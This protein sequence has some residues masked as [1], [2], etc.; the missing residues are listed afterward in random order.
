MSTPLSSFELWSKTLGPRGDA[1]EHARE[2]LR[3]SFL[4]F[5]ERV[6]QLVS[7]LGA[8][9]PGL[10]VHDITHIDALWRVANQI[11]GPDYPLNPAEAYVLGGAFLLHDSAHVLAAYPRG[12]DQ[13]KETLHWQDLIAQRYAGIQPPRHSAEEKSAL[14]QVLR[15]VHAEQAHVLAK[16][17][18]SSPGSSDP[19]YLIENNELRSYYADLIGE[20]AASH[21]WSPD[22]TASRFR[23]RQV[24]CPAFL[25]VDA[26]EVDALKI[27]FLLRTADAA[28]LDDLR[29]PWFLFALRQ[30]QGVSATHW[31][32]QA[33]LGQPKR[34]D[35]GEL[36]LGSGSPFT[37]T[38]RD[39]WWMAYDVAQMVDRELRAAHDI[40]KEEGRPEFAA[41]AVLGVE[42]PRAF[43]R[44]V[45]AR[46]WEPID[47]SP[48]VGNLPHLIS[49]LGG[50][51]LY[52]DNKTAPLRELLQ[53]ALDAVRALRGLGG[54]GASEGEVRVSIERAGNHEWIL[55]V[56]DDGIGMSRHVLTDVLMDFGT[57]LWASDALREELP[58]LAKSGFESVG[59]FGIGF[60]S[61]FMLGSEVKVTTRRYLPGPK[62][63]SVHWQLNFDSGLSTRPALMKPAAS[64]QLPK[65]GTRVAV[66][67]SAQTLGQLL[68]R[69]PQ[70]DPAGAF[71][72]RVADEISSIFPGVAPKK[73]PTDDE[74][75]ATLAW[76]VTRLCPA[77]PVRILSKFGD[78]PGYLS[79][80]PN[81][82]T[83]IGDDLVLARS[84]CKQTPILPL[85]DSRGE[86]IGRIGLTSDEYS[87][88]PASLVFHGVLA[89][90]ANGLA[91]ILTAS[92][93]NIDARREKTSLGG[94]PSAWRRWAEGLLEIDAPM[95]LNQRLR[96]HP[97]VPD[98][99][100][101]VWRWRGE[102]LTLEDLVI[103]LE[104]VDSIVIHNGNIEHEDSDE[105]SS[106]TFRNA[107]SIAD[108][109]ICVPSL[110]PESAWGSVFFHGTEA[111]KPTVFPWALGVAP[112]DYRDRLS[113]ALE[114][115]GL[116]FQ[117][118]SED[119]C[120][121]GYAN[122]TEIY[123]SAE[124]H[125]RE[126]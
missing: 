123:R 73:E 109:V 16:L 92:S 61:V 48:K 86:V 53:N 108:N 33:K 2:K 66:R 56:T 19:L 75:A 24:P 28:H 36:R 6:A 97:V 50:S 34:T 62:F 96:L 114:A 43:A 25:G 45:P 40:L 90:Q 68:G 21:H 54:L 39:A 22:E 49:R 32:F 18:W 20:V 106:Y 35:S 79:V 78:H 52:G 63:D 125:N 87:S 118:V 3:Q 59:K 1:Y 83:T 85:T 72:V 99:D 76:L 94:E 105:L 84:D 74:Q 104:A 110:T 77:S 14:F 116:D 51:A 29:A 37:P 115:S 65:P 117:E 58:G 27:A 10:T 124:T 89:G 60:F 9:L 57:S 113:A 112:I 80:A 5:R 4:S 8:E 103:E 47:A 67:L 31:R 70:K 17:S 15:H 26:W 126:R 88:G 38:E 11:A 44:Q 7:T 102:E 30:P 93:N 42:S 120:L 100:L 13:L 111:T 82:W 119:S 71:L 64:D 107:F 23:D 12:V 55:A 101:R 46:D 121:V 81:D 98:L 91:G 122:G 41:H 95:S 69:T